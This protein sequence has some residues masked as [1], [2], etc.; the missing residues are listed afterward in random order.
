MF[1]VAATLAPHVKADKLKALAMA[2]PSR[3]GMMPELPTMDEAGMPGFD[4][5]IWIGLLAPPGTPADIV[6]KLSNAANEA[7]KT[8]V[9]IKTMNTQGIDTLGATPKEFSD[10]I[11]AD[12]EKW[13]ALLARSDLPKNIAAPLTSSRTCGRRHR[14][15][16]ARYSPRSSSSSSIAAVQICTSG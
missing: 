12:L 11:R 7:L 4:V 1:N 2:Q 13:N 6:D 16:P 15:R 3:A 5:G 10:F 9:V 14:R 8:D